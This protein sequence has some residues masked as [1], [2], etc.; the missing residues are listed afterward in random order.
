[1]EASYKQV[2]IGYNGGGME[3]SKMFKQEIGILRFG[4]LVWETYP[5]RMKSNIDS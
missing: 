1:M 2:G 4:V 3:T 5:T